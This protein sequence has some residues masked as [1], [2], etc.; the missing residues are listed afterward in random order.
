MEQ[1]A[2][3]SDQFNTILKSGQDFF[4]G[5]RHNKSSR[6]P[7]E[8]LKR[9]QREAFSDLMKLRDRQDKVEKI[10]T[11]YKTAKGSPFEENGTVVRAEIG[12]AGN[13]LLVD[14]FDQEKVD[15]I[16]RAGLRTGYDA[17]ITFETKVRQTDVLEAEFIC[18]QRNQVD[19]GDVL[20]GALSLAR[21]SYA[22]NMTDWLSVIAIPM[23]ARCKDLTTSTGSLLTEKGLTDYSSFG[24]PLLHQNHGSAI[25]LTVKS[26]NI[27]GSLAQFV[28]DLPGSVGQCFST[29][30]Q[31]VY[32]LPR[33]SKLSLFG[34]HQVPKLGLPVIPGSLTIPSS[35]WR[36]HQ[37]PETSSETSSRP[38]E[39]MLGDSV[40]VMLESEI[41]ESTRVRGW[42]QKRNGNPSYLQWSVGM[43]DF[44]EEEIGWGLNLGGSILGPKSWDHF[45]IEAFLKFNLGKRLSVQP[46]FIYLMDGNNQMPVLTVRSTWSI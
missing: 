10:L 20:E 2:S 18:G 42:V 32:Q 17:R 5:N 26:S 45:Q 14:N 3:I 46:G 8:I 44:P 43:S 29:F 16:K 19:S 28:V 37:Y 12:V 39:I 40:A 36:R 27:V 11:F 41:D 15:T 23:G 1:F 35:I 21:V 13:M 30:G 22:A 38:L 7:I 34:L 9:L 33:A 6:N 25:G 24:P 31:I 4:T